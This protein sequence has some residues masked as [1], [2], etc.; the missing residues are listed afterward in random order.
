MSLL[1]PSRATLACC[2]RDSR[3]EILGHRRDHARRQ[4]LS[5]PRARWSSCRRSSRDSSPPAAR[6]RRPRPESPV[7]TSSACWSEKRWRMPMSADTM[8]TWFQRFLENAASRSDLMSSSP[9][10][11]PPASRCAA[12]IRACRRWPVAR[13]DAGPRTGQ[14]QQRQRGQ[15]NPHQPPADQPQH[16]KEQ[17]EERNVGRGPDGRR[18]QKL[19]HLI[20]LADL[21]AMKLPVDLG[22]AS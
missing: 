17:E 21:W 5:C 19:A 2:Q 3:L 16:A 8:F 9:V 20:N 7:S 22:R 10:P 4:D 6:R 14:Q 1:R 12:P 18:R 15:R 11:P 13:A